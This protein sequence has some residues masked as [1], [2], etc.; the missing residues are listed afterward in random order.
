VDE[1]RAVGDQKEDEMNAFY[2]R[3]LEEQGMIFVEPDKKAISQAAMPVIKRE[4]A[5]LDPAVAAEVER[6]SK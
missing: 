5:E 6:L 1:A 4:V 2:R 3:G